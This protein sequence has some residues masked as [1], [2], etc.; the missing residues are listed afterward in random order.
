MDRSFMDI[1]YCNDY[2]PIGRAARDEFLNINNSA[3]DAAFDFR[4]FTANCFKTCYY[5]DKHYKESKNNES[6]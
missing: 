4:H 6:N 1:T 5:K 3:F 2:C